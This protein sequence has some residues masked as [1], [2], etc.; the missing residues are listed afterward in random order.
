[1]PCSDIQNVRF[2]IWWMSSFTVQTWQKR[3][4]RQHFLEKLPFKI[5]AK[6]VWHDAQS[7]QSETMDNKFNS[8]KTTNQTRSTW[9]N[10]VGLV[11]TVGISCRAVPLSYPRAAIWLIPVARFSNCFSAA[12]FIHSISKELS[13][14]NKNVLKCHG[15]SSSSLFT[16]MQIFHQG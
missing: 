13:S 7:L 4:T 3:C 2:E 6:N 12:R 10:W 16:N 15:W 9:N 1:M 8:N 5:C 14:K 11:A